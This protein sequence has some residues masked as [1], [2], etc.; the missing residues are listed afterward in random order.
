MQ[1]DDGDTGFRLVRNQP[2]TASF[3]LVS[4]VTGLRTQVDL[5]FIVADATVTFDEYIDGDSGGDHGLI[6]RSPV[7]CAIASHKIDST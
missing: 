6:I 2:Y 3:L 7:P 4:P 5:S 1:I